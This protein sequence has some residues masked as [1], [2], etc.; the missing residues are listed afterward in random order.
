MEMPVT[1]AVLVAGVLLL[2]VSAWRSSKPYV[3][4]IRA[5]WIPWKFMVLLGGA[6]VLY[7]GIHLLSLLG[8]HAGQGGQ[9]GLY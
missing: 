7:G 3:D 2:L 1:I 6:L 8:L 5:R 4:S 9:R